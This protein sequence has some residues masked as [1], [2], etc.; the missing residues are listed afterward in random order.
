MLF[1]PL[2]TTKSKGIGLG[3]IVSK[4]LVEINGGRIE[5]ESEEGRGA[6]FSVILPA[7]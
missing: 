3:L 4:N 7:R 6:V 2:F 1:E 5:F